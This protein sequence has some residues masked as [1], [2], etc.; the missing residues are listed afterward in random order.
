MDTHL[1]TYNNLLYYSS[2]INETLKQNLIDPEWKEYH[3]RQSK[4][5]KIDVKDKKIKVIYTNY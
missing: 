3:N 2:K 1:S 4:P 5:L